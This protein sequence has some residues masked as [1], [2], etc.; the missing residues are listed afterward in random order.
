MFCAGKQFTVNANN[1]WALVG[2]NMMNWFTAWSVRG[3]E[4][5]TAQEAKIMYN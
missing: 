4:C 1:R 3:I 2:I 5:A